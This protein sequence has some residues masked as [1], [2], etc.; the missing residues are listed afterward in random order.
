MNIP[1]M[2]DIIQ[3]WIQCDKECTMLLS[4]NPGERWKKLAVVYENLFGI[5]PNVTLHRADNDVRICAEVYFKLLDK[6]RA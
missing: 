1:H 5:A 4:C 3:S 6:I 2:N